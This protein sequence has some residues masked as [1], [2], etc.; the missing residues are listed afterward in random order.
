MC[1]QLWINS[2][3][4]LYHTVLTCKSPWDVPLTPQVPLELLVWPS[5]SFQVLPTWQAVCRPHS[6]KLG[7]SLHSSFPQVRGHQLPGPSGFHLK[8]PSSRPLF[9]GCLTRV[10]FP[11]MELSRQHLPPSLFLSDTGELS[12]MQTQPGWSLTKASYLSHKPV[13][14]HLWNCSSGL[15]DPLGVCG[16]KEK[17]SSWE[18][19]GAK[20]EVL[21]G[22]LC[23]PSSSITKQTSP[24]QCAHSSPGQSW[25]MN[26]SLISPTLFPDV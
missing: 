15:L 21:C 4:A 16:G 22:R 9:Q 24:Q 14:P 13:S 18:E 11:C 12:P 19:A 5:H 26:W 7:S 2:K 6:C 20:A 23:C 1:L 10:T 3:Q 8:S 17:L 25:D